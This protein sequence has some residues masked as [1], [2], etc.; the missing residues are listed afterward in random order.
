MQAW[1][2]TSSS[3]RWWSARPAPA[4]YS[5]SEF[6]SKELPDLDVSLRGAV[7][8]AR[9]LQDPLAELVK[10]DPKSI[11]VGQYQHDVNQSGLARTLDAVVEDCVNGVGVDLNTASA[12]LLSRVSGLSRRGGG[13]HRA[14]ARRHGAF[15]NRRS[16]WT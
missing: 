4:V 15:R 9:R 6:A 13:Q 5:A 2:P 11:G 3:T 1:H 14:L 12:P 10:I 7:S 8:I 16:C